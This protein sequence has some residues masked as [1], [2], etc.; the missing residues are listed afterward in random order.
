M[1]EQKLDC[2]RFKARD[3]S[4]YDPV[5]DK[6]DHFTERFTTPLAVKLVEL[7]APVRSARILDLGTGTG[8]VAIHAA[9]RLES[10]GEVLDLTEALPQESYFSDAYTHFTED[11]NR[12]V[13]LCG[14]VIGGA[15]LR[16]LHPCRPTELCA[17]V[18]D[19]RIHDCLSYR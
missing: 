9:Q 1:P 14:M 18:V 17:A 5:V 11:G 10:G 8:V 3:A 6:F 19:V 2:E 7:A 13:A 12:I 4:S 16:I 15:V